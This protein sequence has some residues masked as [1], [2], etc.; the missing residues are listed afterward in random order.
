MTRTIWQASVAAAAL[1]TS[2]PMAAQTAPAK[3][4]MDASR[5]PDERSAL[6]LAQM[7]LDEKIAMVNGT[8]GSAR[9]ML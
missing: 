8:F 3:A 5:T 9:G 4:W 6:I 2:V 1:M 7:T